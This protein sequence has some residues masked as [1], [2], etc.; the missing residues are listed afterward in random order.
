MER[1][2]AA[3]R[4]TGRS[5]SRL[6]AGPSVVPPSLLAPATRFPH[7]AAR[8]PSNTAPGPAFLVGMWGSE[9]SR[10]AA[11]RPPTWSSVLLSVHLSVRPSAGGQCCGVNRLRLSGGGRRA[12]CSRCVSPQGMAQA[13]GAPRPGAGQPHVFKLVL[14]GSGSVGKSSLA[15][16]YVKDDFRSILPTVGCE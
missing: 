8:H 12:A 16:R 3:G 2:Q 14:L 4:V 10:V 9:Q 7:T 6:R 15:I 5:W 1:G 11:P 13:A